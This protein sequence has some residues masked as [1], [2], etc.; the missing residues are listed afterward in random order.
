MIEEMR[1]LEQENAHLKLINENLN[2]AM[3]EEREL[4]K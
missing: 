2:K 1:N 4:F 3:A